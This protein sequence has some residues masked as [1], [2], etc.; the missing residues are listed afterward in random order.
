M[1]TR[2]LGVP[3]IDGGAAAMVGGPPVLEDC[4]A[5]GPGDAGGSDGGALTVAPTW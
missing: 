5:I 4:G 1:F 3:T 2:V